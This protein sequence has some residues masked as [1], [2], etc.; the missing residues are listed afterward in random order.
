MNQ[1]ME[2]EPVPVPLPSYCFSL[3]RNMDPNSKW[4]FVLT[5]FRQPQLCL[6]VEHCSPISLRAILLDTRTPSHILEQIAHCYCDDDYIIHDLVRCPHLPESALAFIALA[7]SDEIR[8]FISSTRVVD[9]VVGDESGETAQSAPRERKRLNLTQQI[10]RMTTPQKIR[11]GM[12]GA[13]EARGLLIRDSNKQIALAVLDNP[14]ITDGEIESFAKSANLSEDVIRGIGMNPEWSRK[15]SVSLALVN[16][17]KTPPSIS[18]P[19]VNRMT[20]KDLSMLEKNKNVSQAVRTA[21]RALVAK[22]K[23]AKNK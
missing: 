14:R 21:V 5:R 13:K 11:L 9:I 4:K 20:D 2:E 18:V 19:I 15:Y 17:P 1:L 10:Q 22:R 3:G 8:Q 6:D 16:N 12:R 23:V 7:A